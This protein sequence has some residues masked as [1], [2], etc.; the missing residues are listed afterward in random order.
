MV[1]SEEYMYPQTQHKC[2]MMRQK[3]EQIVYNL[4][5][6]HLMF[7]SWAQSAMV[8]LNNLFLWQ[9]WQ[10]ASLISL[11]PYMFLTQHA[12]TGA[13]SSQ[14]ALQP[15]CSP[16]SAV[17]KRSWDVWYTG[18][19][20]RFVHLK[21][22]CIHPTLVIKLESYWLWHLLTVYCVNELSVTNLLQRLYIILLP[23]TVMRGKFRF[24][25]GKY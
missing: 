3:T 19:R 15:K 23:Q 17:N 14:F 4:C 11:A 24:H 2:W 5:Q 13:V 1:N 20:A 9:T 21:I 10:C 16:W 25:S 7:M 6:Q 22:V 8:L 12:G 18:G